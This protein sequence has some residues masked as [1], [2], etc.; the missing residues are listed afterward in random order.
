LAQIHHFETIIGA[1]WKLTIHHPRR[2][3][4]KPY[5]KPRQRVPYHALDLTYDAVIRCVI[6]ATPTFETALETDVCSRRQGFCFVKQL[7][8]IGRECETRDR[9]SGVRRLSVRL[10]SL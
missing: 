7:A 8:A 4:C 10:I 2:M 6:I 9:R 3:T 5:R 1:V